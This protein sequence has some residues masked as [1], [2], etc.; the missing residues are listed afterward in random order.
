MTL[1]E[2]YERLAAAMALDADCVNALIDAELQAEAAVLR[3]NERV[4]ALLCQRHQQHLP[5]IIE[6]G[7]RFPAEYVRARL[8]SLGLATLEP[9]LRFPGSSAGPGDSSATAI[10]NQTGAMEVL[11]LSAWSFTR[12]VSDP[13]ATLLRVPDPVAALERPSDAPGLSEAGATFR[14]L[15]NE[16][17]TLTA[18]HRSVITALIARGV[19]SADPS[20]SPSFTVGYA[21]AGPLFLA[22]VQWLHRVATRDACSRLGFVGTAGDLLRDAYLAWWGNEAL[23]VGDP[24]RPGQSLGLVTVTLD[25]IAH[26]SHEARS[27]RS[28][29]RH[30]AITGS[31]L[32]RADQRA[33]LD[34]R[35]SAEGGRQ[36]R[37]DL[38][39][40]VLRLLFCPL[41]RR[42]ELR[43]GAVAFISAHRNEFGALP[44]TLSTIDRAV[45]YE[46]LEHLLQTASLTGAHDGLWVT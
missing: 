3:P 13:G 27:T 30:Y 14:R 36:A 43:R 8:R 44:P 1:S 17:F 37:Q 20:P 22:F 24:T 9:D 2:V 40:G 38:Q 15:A 21:V 28:S 5:V 25:P 7:A 32:A 4:V 26:D 10:G 16:P 23:P 45:G 31:S 29:V 34:A 35:L 42:L 46:P 19:A 33:F 41:H 11:H 12:E 6:C 18:T 39:Q